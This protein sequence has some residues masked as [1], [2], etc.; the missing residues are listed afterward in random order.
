M[1][2]AFGNYK[3]I[4]KEISFTDVMAEWLSFTKNKSLQYNLRKYESETHPDEVSQRFGVTS[5]AILSCARTYKTCKI[6]LS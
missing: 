4:L 1:R 2:H 6:F 3:D 5:I